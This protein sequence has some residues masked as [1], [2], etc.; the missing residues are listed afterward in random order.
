MQK[1]NIT[2]KI[3]SED[4]CDSDNFHTL[5]FAQNFSSEELNQIYKVLETANFTNVAY[6]NFMAYLRTAIKFVQTQKDRE[7]KNA[8]NNS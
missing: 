4:Y 3:D 6:A 5:K 1:I 8:L 2:I 7:D